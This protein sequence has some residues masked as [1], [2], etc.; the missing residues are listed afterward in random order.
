MFAKYYLFKDE[1]RTNGI[2]LDKDEYNKT[3][4]KIKMWTKKFF[5]FLL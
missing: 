5:T 2:R 3:F 1:Y 4:V